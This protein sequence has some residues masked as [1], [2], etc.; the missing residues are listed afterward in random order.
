MRAEGRLV[1]A[2]F[3]APPMG[4][5]VPFVLDLAW[6]LAVVHSNQP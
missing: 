1:A 2:G 3:A 6:D 4:G 5:L